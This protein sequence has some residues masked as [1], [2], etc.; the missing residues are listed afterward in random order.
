M[1]EFASTRAAADLNGV[2]EGCLRGLASS[3]DPMTVG[4]IAEFAAG[5]VQSAADQ[6]PVRDALCML[7]ALGW[8]EPS[9]G[10]MPYE[11]A[12]WRITDEGRV[13]LSSSVR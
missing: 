11:A 6:V 13:A 8:A 3:D 7:D 1:T 2:E 5:F 4:D 10:L 9:D 12:A